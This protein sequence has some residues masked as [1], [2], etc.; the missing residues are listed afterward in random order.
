VLLKEEQ[1]SPDLDAGDFLCENL[2]NVVYKNPCTI[3][4]LETATESQIKT[5]STEILTNALRLHKVSDLSGHQTEYISSIL[6]LSMN[7]SYN[8]SQ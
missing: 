3:E 4:E 7:I 6:K 8:F 1:K 2:K 5:I